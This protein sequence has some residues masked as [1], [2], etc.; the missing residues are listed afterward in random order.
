MCKLPPNHHIPSGLYISDEV[1]SEAASRFGTPIYL[2]DDTT[3]HQCWDLLSASLPENTVIYYSV[4]ANP[5][6]T[7][8]DRFRQLEAHFEIASL[9]ELMAT[10]CAGVAPSEI[11]FVG[12]GKSPRELEYAVRRGLEA[13]V[14]ESKREVRDLQILSDVLDLRTRVAL[15]VN[16]GF[17][18][19]SLAMGGATQFGMD[20]TTALSILLNAG[21]YDKLDLIGIHGYL[22]AR[23]LDWRVICEHSRLILEIADDLQQKSGVEFSFIDIG[24]GFGIPCY[25]KEQSLD[26][27]ALRIG[28]TELA[29]QY[30]RE[31]PQTEGIRVESGRFLVGP[32]GI[33]VS[34]VLDVKVSL[35]QRFVI[36]DGGV[37]VFG[38]HD[39]YLGSRPSPVRV[40]GRRGD[41]EAFTLCGPLCTPTD[42]L[43]ANVCLPK[44]EV[45][46]LVI[47]YL[48]GAYGLTASPGLF[49]SHGFPSEVLLCN[50]D[51]LLIRKPLPLSALLD[52]QL[53]G[54]VL[55]TL[56]GVE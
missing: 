49:L 26:L 30:C 20:P 38:G 39:L 13:I 52:D 29:D 28:L 5:N 33:F 14:A 2:Y 31:H 10:A 27:E 54:P 12:P 53:P 1:V 46:D 4:K 22:G 32:C 37:N 40:L 44:P 42:R 16:P 35:N 21:N 56:P 34:R 7:I 15:R 36:L 41:P 55:G 6:V 17:G 47:F 11:I 9:G 45:G 48:A 23:I 50:G 19:G 8:I 24:G 18:R 3:L 43:A 51:L 25:K